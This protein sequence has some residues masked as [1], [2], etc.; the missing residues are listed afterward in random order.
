MTGFRK[1][2]LLA[3]NAF[4]TF[5]AFIFKNALAANNG[6]WPAGE[7]R[8]GGGELPRGYW[9][10]LRRGRKGENGGVD[11]QEVAQKRGVRRD[12]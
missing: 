4:R 11:Y 2:G 8:G 3:A 9:G 10:L 12:A 6:F 1:T 7:N 5:L